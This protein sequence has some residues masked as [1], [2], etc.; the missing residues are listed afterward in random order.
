MIVAAGGQ[1]AAIGGKR[2]AVDDVGVAL[3]AST[4]AAGEVPEEDAA[5]APGRSESPAIRRKR[6]GHRPV[7]M[8][9]AD[10]P[11]A[12]TRKVQH[13]NLP[14]ARCMRQ[15]ATVRRKRHGIRGEFLGTALPEAL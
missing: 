4:L 6:Q 14:A 12:A 8:T 5:V 13:A 1:A 2:Y 10:S 11:L 15:C 9:A 7:G 3:Q